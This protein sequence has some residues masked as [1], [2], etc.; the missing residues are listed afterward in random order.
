MLALVHWRVRG[1]LCGLLLTL[2]VFRLKNSGIIQ[3]WLGLLTPEPKFLLLAEIFADLG[4][5]ESHDRM[6]EVVPAG[7]FKLWR[8]QRSILLG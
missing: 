3:G 7:I 8:H 6:G 5:G 2:L 1:F 4:K